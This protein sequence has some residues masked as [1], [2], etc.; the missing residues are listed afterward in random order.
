MTASA[1][2][3]GIAT[4]VDQNVRQNPENH[5]TYTDYRVRFSEVWKGGPGDPFVV[6]K[7]GG[8][9]DGHT[10]SIVG[11][12]YVL[13]NGES[14]VFFLHPSL[15]GAINAVIGIRHGLYRIQAGQPALVFRVSGPPGSSA[16]AKPLTLPELKE[17]VYRAL[18]KELEAPSKPKSAP[19]ER[20]VGVT[21]DAP[22]KRVPDLLP[23]PD[24]PL[25]SARTP[26]V[27]QPRSALA[28]GAV[29]LIVAVMG[30]IVY[31][32]RR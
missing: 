15:G 3:I 22:L 23:A 19:S 6:T 12:D 27:L 8:T 1:T 28:L 16:K 30:I 32:A 25:P 31:R 17:Q 4:V 21:P 2:V 26:S 5:M 29:L 24:P 20:E 11:Q 13:Q 10:V 9:L 14:L 18:G 7:A